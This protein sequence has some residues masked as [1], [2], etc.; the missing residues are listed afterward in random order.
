MRLRTGRFAYPNSI[1]KLIVQKL[2]SD[3]TAQRLLVKDKREMA[4]KKNGHKIN[5]KYSKVSIYY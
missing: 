3:F 5:L 2:V 1:G 4:K